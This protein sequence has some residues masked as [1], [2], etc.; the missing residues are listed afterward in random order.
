[1][2]E[3]FAP[4]ELEGIAAAYKQ[5]AGFVVPDTTEH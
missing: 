3:V 4:G 1:M 5:T 2:A